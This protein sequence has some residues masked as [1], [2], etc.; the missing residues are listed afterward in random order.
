MKGVEAF[1]EAVLKEFALLSY[2][3]LLL[4]ESEKFQRNELSPLFGLD[5][6]SEEPASSAFRLLSCWFLAWL[7]LQP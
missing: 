2:N 5:K 3:A 1:A 4:A 6:S 7:V